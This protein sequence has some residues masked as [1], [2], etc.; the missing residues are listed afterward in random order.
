M[1]QAAEIEAQKI[2]K[3]FGGFA[4]LEDVSLTVGR[5]DF[6]TL[7]GPSGSGKTTFLMLLSGFEHVTSG[8][9][10]LDGAD[11]TATPAEKRGF[12]MV[13]Q[14]YALFPHMTV[15]ENIAF[16]LK[17]QKRDPQTIKRRVAQMIEM[18][19]LGGHGHK[20]PSALSGGQQ[21]RVALARALAYE[22]SVLLLDEPFSALDK[23]LR[24]QMQDEM[25]RIHRETGTT[26]VFVTHDQSEALALSS[27]I[28]IFE[29]GRLQQLG[30]PREVYERPENRFV[31]EFLGDINILDAEFDGADART[32]GRTLKLAEPTDR[33][34][35]HIA[36]RPEYMTVAT[37]P[38]DDRNSICGRV[39]D[40]TYLGAETR[41]TLET[42]GGTPLILHVPTA[43]LPPDA[44]TGAELWASWKAEN[45]F[46]L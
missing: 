19:G 30:P 36:I 16:P 17:V 7:L 27:R 46:L 39:T 41:L 1:T 20:K 43:A 10:L 2:G 12:G 34:S 44:A 45:S 9:L 18:T 4:A 37:A 14:G 13:F 23:N 29:R 35:G 24:E 33:K 15:E 40:M 28:A 3:K 32:E 21:Q 25:R 11:M 22:P 26:F 31:A 5:G 42:P 8:R 38:L 6:L